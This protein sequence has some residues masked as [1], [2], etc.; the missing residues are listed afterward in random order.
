MSKKTDDLIYLSII[1]RQIV[2][3]LFET[4]SFKYY[5]FHYENGKYYFNSDVL[6][7]LILK[8]NF[9]KLKKI[10]NTLKNEHNFTFRCLEIKKKA[11][12]PYKKEY[13]FSMN[14]EF[15]DSLNLENYDPPNVLERVT[16]FFK[17]ICIKP[18]IVDDDVN[19]EIFC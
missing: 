15:F 14:K 19:M 3:K 7:C 13:I 10:I 16:R 9:R 4:D 11:Y 6:K 8:E 2:D 1:F 18:I 17:R 12:F 5:N